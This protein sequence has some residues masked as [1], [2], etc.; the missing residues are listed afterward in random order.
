[1]STEMKEKQCA[2]TCLYRIEESLVNGDLKEAERTAI[3]LLKSL[4]E[5]QRLEE[6]RADQAQL[7]KMVQR[8]KEKGIPAELIARVG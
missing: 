7:E 3:D 6:E 2:H 1:M 4:R 5:L 8:L